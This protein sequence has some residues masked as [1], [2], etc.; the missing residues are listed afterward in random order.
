M[1]IDGKKMMREI[2]SVCKSIKINVNNNS[3]IVCTNAEE[4]LFFK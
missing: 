3:W 2:Y 1:N 4:V